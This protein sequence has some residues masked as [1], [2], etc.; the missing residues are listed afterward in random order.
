MTH[1]LRARV[2]SKVSRLGECWIWHGY[3]H[4][5][6]PRM[7][8]SSDADRAFVGAPPKS[9]CPA[10]QQ[11]YV[12]RVS[13][14]LHTGYSPPKEGVLR[15]TC[16]NPRCVSPFHIEHADASNK[17][18]V[19]TLFETFWGNVDV[20]GPDDCWEWKLGRGTDGY[21]S[22][23]ISAEHAAALEMRPGTTGAHRV[24]WALSHGKPPPKKYFVL[25]SCD[26]P[27]C[28]N[29]KH[30]RLGTPADNTRDWVERSRP[31]RARPGQRKLSGG[32][33]ADLRELRR[34]GKTVKELAGMFGVAPSTVSWHI[35]DMRASA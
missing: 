16:R 15:S 26:N 31:G 1:A 3:A 28:V 20:R 33:I 5:G 4:K 29:P 2:L 25:H 23:S 35:R 12:R 7:V 6:I 17:V 21:G 22:V 8:V 34:E 19:S 18:V 14:A 11:V 32:D 9:R 30:L 24:A 27:P 10:I 13:W